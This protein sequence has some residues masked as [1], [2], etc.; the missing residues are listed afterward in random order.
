M[1]HSLSTFSYY[2]GGKL[3]NQFFL[4]IVRSII[5]AFPLSSVSTF[6]RKRFDPNDI[7]KRVQIH[8]PPRYVSL[9]DF[10]GGNLRVNIN[11]HIGWNIYLQGYFDVIH[12]AA[13][14]LFSK[15]IPGV[16]VDV[17]A[18]IGSVSIPLAAKRKIEVIAIEASPTVASELEANVALNSP[19]PYTVINLAVTSPENTKKKRFV[20]MYSPNGNTAA[21]SLIPQWNPSQ[22]SP[23]I[24]TVRTS[25]VDEILNFLGIKQI[26]VIKIDV[27]GSEYQALEGMKNSLGLLPAILFEWRP[28]VMK[29]MGKE[30]NDVRRLFP[31]EYT[32]YTI[33]ADVLRNNNNSIELTLGAFKLEQPT[34][35]VLAIPK[36]ITPKKMSLAEKDGVFVSYPADLFKT[37]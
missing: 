10:F 29:R 11:D 24:E 36:S 3:R 5:R 31:S 7:R 37:L 14:V 34:E 25:T 18:N 16:F 26:S 19:I 8:L 2:I 13:G 33:K 23:N 20:P 35:N 1:K 21:S 15:S 27:E 12:F 9:V 28:D 6:L 30:M 4:T 32:F 17:G 22:I